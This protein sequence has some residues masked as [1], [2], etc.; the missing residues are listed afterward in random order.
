[1]TRSR[2][3]RWIAVPLTALALLTAACGDDSDKDDNAS[4]TTEATVAV[5]DGIVVGAGINDP[6]DPNIAVLTFLPAKVTVE[7]GTDVTWEW[8]GTE[9]HSVTFVPDGQDAP[10]V[11]TDPNAA[12]PIPATGPIDGKTLV[13]SG[14]QPLGAAATPFTTSF[15]TAG[16]YK[17]IC[18]IHPGM[19]GEVDVV[20]AGGDADSRLMW[21]RLALPTR[22]STWPRVRRPRRIS[23]LRV[24]PR[25]TTATARRRGPLRWA[26]PPSTP[27]CWPSPRARPT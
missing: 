3:F 13:S 5:P 26:P 7:A 15:A 18:I 12:A 9:P 17:Y 22:R 4:S 23:W 21:P 11:E 16:T 14:L 2:G 6:A 25:R 10:D 8:S 1:M 24:R 20:E 19:T 27:T